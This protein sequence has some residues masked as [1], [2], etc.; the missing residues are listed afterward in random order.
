MNKNYRVV[1][2]TLTQ[3]YLIPEYISL[4]DHD[5]IEEWFYR[6]PLHQSHVTRDGNKL[7]GSQKVL[8]TE[9]MSL[10]KYSLKINYDKYKKITDAAF[11][12]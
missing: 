12:Y 5:L 11:P 2:V 4:S 1:E 10:G 6:F 3:S 9:I 7:G 8:K